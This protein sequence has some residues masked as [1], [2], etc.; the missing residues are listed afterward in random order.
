MGLY[1]DTLESPLGQIYLAATDRGLA[2]CA[3][4]R[5]NGSE[6]TSW[7]AKN[8]PGYTPVKGQNEVLATAIEQLKAY[9][10]GKSKNLAV[11]LELIGTS[12]R[13]KVWQAL[14]T[15]PY[16]ETRTYGEVAKQIGLPQGSRAV[17]QANHHNPVSYF[18]P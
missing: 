18:V 17:G 10:A 8:L 2:Y 7:L 16:G 14:R 15:I 1:W 6:M 12:F 11:P 3:S 13:R 4:K 5:E 9:F